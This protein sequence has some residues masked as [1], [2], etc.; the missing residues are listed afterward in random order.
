MHANADATGQV[1]LHYGSFQECLVKCRADPECKS[2]VFYKNAGPYGGH[3]F[4]YG[5][6]CYLTRG[7]GLPNY[8]AVAAALTGAGN[9]GA[10]T[11]AN[12]CEY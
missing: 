9:V 10:I 7:W 12:F 4:T 2:S 11:N 5:Y 3:A 1:S 8:P 6:V